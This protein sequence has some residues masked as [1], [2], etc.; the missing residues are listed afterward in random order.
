MVRTQQG[1]FIYKATYSGVP[2]YEVSSRR[3]AWDAPTAAL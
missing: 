1:E 2:V 3:C